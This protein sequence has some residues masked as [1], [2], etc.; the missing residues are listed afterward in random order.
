MIQREYYS[1]PKWDAFRPGNPERPARERE[2][3]RNVLQKTWEKRCGSVAD[4]VS[5]IVAEGP[6][7]TLGPIAE[8][9]GWKTNPGQGRVISIEMVHDV[10]FEAED[11]DADSVKGH[12]VA[13]FEISEDADKCPTIPTETYMA[14][15]G[16][17]LDLGDNLET[18]KSDEANLW[19]IYETLVMFDDADLQAYGLD[20]LFEQTQAILAKEFADTSVDF[21]D[22]FDTADQSL[23]TFSE[24][25]LKRLGLERAAK[26]AKDGYDFQGAPAPTVP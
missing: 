6:E 26:A 3:W 7:N 25:G 21:R 12:M 4:Y 16:D 14:G 18:L 11:P 15:Y 8:Y 23:A 10:F 1:Q 24:T 5:D 9:N 19:A 22:Y 2:N 20:V 17:I 13:R